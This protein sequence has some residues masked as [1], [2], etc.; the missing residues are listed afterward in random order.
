M[1]YSNNR[2]VQ[3]KW[4]NN[5]YSIHTGSQKCST[6]KK[7]NKASCRRIKTVWFHLYKV[8][9]YAKPAMHY[10][11]NTYRRSKTMKKRHQL[12]NTKFKIPSIFLLV[13]N[14]IKLERGTKETARYW[15]VLTYSLN[16]VMVFLTATHWVS[17]YI[18]TLLY[19]FDI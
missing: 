4:R 15:L 9:K 3:C 13:G 7:N 10:F 11:Q 8:Q 5:S 16:H 12:I 6:E 19:V 14:G 17:I 1:V 18:N 2:T